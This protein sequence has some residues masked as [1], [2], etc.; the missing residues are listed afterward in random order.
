MSTPIFAKLSAELH[1]HPKARRAGYHGTNVFRVVLELNAL[2]GAT[3]RL[4]PAISEPYY[5][6]DAL[7]CSETEA[8]QGLAAAVRAKFLEVDADGSISIVGWDDDEWGRGGIGA[9]F[10]GA[11][12]KSSTYVVQRGDAGPVKIG[13]ATN[14][15]SRLATLQTACPED[16]LLLYAVEADVEGAL[17]ASLDRHR[18]RGEWFSAS[19]D[20]FHDLRR[21]LAR[22]GLGEI[23]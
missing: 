21:E 20:F 16:L 14:V 8:A 11:E 18:I 2:H 3:G 4:S 6:A 15:V 23:S 9:L 5:L 12:R 10:L 13:R 22:L 7:M 19:A 17:H 1:R